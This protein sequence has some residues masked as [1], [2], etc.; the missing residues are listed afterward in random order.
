MAYNQRYVGFVEEN[1]DPKRLGRI[2][3]RVLGVFEAIP[4]EHLPWASPYIHPDGKSFT[5]PAIGKIVNIIYDDNNI[6]HPYYLYTNRYNINLQDK[7]ESLS[8][9]EYIDF[10]SLLFDHRTRVYSDQE[11]LT[12]DYLINKIKIKNDSINL[13]LKDNDQTLNLGTDG[14]TQQAVL[15]NAFFDWF[16]RFMEKLLIPS[17]LLGNLAAPILKPEIDALITEY[18]GIRETFI[19]NHVKIVDNDSVNTLERDAITSEVEHDDT[20]V[21]SIDDNTGEAINIEESNAISDNARQTI[22]KKQEIEKE[23][24]KNA[25]PK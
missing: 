18:Q 4:T 8:N 2:R 1:N 22:M 23:I 17:S 15:G 12:F 6:Y 13:E 9:D 3:V 10:V 24:I 25:K 16:D 19:S 20:D 14:A 11:G 5:V 21:L 7:L